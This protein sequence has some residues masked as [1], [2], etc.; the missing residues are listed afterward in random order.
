MLIKAQSCQTSKLEEDSYNQHWPSFKLRH[1]RR[2]GILD[3][4]M[5]GREKRCNIKRSCD[6]FSCANLRDRLVPHFRKGG[7][8]WKLLSAKAESSGNAAVVAELSD[9]PSYCYLPVCQNL[10]VLTNGGKKKH[11]YKTLI[12]NLVVELNNSLLSASFI[13]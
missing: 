10:Q 12:Y 7:T 9:I 5:E 11:N 8:R 13:N 1:R 4:Q 6:K 3:H 2:S